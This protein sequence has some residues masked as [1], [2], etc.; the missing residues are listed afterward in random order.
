MTVS[1]QH[2]SAE[3]MLP[4]RQLLESKGDIALLHLLLR[5]VSSQV[6]QLPSTPRSSQEQARCLLTEQVQSVS[7]SD[8][9]IYIYISFLYS[10]KLVE[11][12]TP[13]LADITATKQATRKQHNC[14]HCMKSG[15][16]G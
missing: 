3:E 7:I 2:T 5:L 9:N 16:G 12:L 6:L 15:M 4:F 14:E 13:S 10:K 1:F 11:M 8:S